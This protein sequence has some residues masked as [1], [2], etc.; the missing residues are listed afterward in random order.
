MQSD[1]FGAFVTVKQPKRAAIS[2][3]KADEKNIV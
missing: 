3:L 2:V 1:P